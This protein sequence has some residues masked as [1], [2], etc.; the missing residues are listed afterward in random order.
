MCLKEIELNLKLSVS[1]LKVILRFIK[2]KVLS[3]VWLCFASVT[4][5]RGG[6]LFLKPC[7]GKRLSS[8]AGDAFRNYQRSWRPPAPS[9]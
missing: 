2:Q 1:T 8:M 5:E 9:N 6:S 7:G 4:A 3:F